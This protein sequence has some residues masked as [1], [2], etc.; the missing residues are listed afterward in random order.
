M[1]HRALQVP[2]DARAAAPYT[3]TAARRVIM[4]RSNRAAHSA[5][6]TGGGGGRGRLAVAVAASPLRSV[7]ARMMRVRPWRRGRSVRRVFLS[8]AMPVQRRGR[9]RQTPLRPPSSVVA[10]DT[11]RRRLFWD[12]AAAIIPVT[13]ASARSVARATNP[14]RAPPSQLP[15]L[16]A[17]AATARPSLT[18]LHR[19][20]SRIRRACSSVTPRA[21][22]RGDSRTPPAHSVA[23][24]GG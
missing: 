14:C 3:V 23:R 7:D 18:R 24:R 11:R 19:S 2:V 4:Q 15:E 8:L 17:E 13:H 9:G 22:R 10:G 20:S 1:P 6:D 5:A 21:G 12:A 16:A